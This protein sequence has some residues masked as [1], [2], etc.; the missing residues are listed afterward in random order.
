MFAIMYQ[1]PVGFV[2]CAVPVSF[3]TYKADA[4]EL[5]ERLTTFDPDWHNESWIAP[6]ITIEEVE[7]T[8]QEDGNEE[9]EALKG[10]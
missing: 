5:V 1:M 7:D 6:I 2:G 4:V 8:P 10:L 9:W 3:T